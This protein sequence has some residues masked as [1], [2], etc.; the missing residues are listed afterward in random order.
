MARHLLLAFSAATPG[1]EAEY[2]RWYDDVHLGEVRSAVPEVTNASRYELT[3][4][5][6]GEFP[7]HFLA[8]YEIEAEDVDAVRRKLQAAV[9][10]MNIS[11]AIAFDG[12]TAGIFQPL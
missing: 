10:T 4:Q 3:Q 5:M 2:H 9:P 1:Q 8:I 7:A 6:R 12:V 11:P